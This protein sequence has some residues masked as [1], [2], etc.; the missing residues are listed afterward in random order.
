MNLQELRANW[1]EYGRTDPM[2][3]I[4]SLPG[5][6]GGR[7]T[8][9][10][11]FD[12][13]EREIGELLQQIAVLGLSVKPGKALDFGCGV[14]RLTQALAHHFD[15][16]VGVDIAPSMVQ[17]AQRLNQHGARCRYLL[18]ARSDLTVLGSERFDLIYTSIVLQHMRPKYAKHYLREFIRVLAPGG[19]LVFQLPSEPR[20]RNTAKP[21]TLVAS[22]KRL[23]RPL[24]PAGLLQAYWKRNLYWRQHSG[25]AR[26]RALG[27]MRRPWPR[28]EMHAIPRRSVEQLLAR[29][30]G[31]LIHVAEN[32]HAGADWVSLRYYVRA[33]TT[34][35]SSAPRR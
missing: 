23:V 5:R 18:N 24:I 28:M 20:Y 16:V 9:E 3:A 26:W 30:G 11:F 6:E 32:D 25:V 31:R 35:A 12:T 19:I 22:M 34:I 15:G 29:S 7:W 8:R 4:L 27:P 17:E 14:G 13:G 2:W 21:A 10:E 1:D 33:P